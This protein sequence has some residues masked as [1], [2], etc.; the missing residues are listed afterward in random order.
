MLVEYSPVLVKS[1]EQHLDANIHMLRNIIHIS[2][3]SRS[4][5]EKDKRRRG[6]SINEEMR[7]WEIKLQDCSNGGAGSILPSFSLFSPS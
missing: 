7:I 1:K 3:H 4:G 2:N 5:K 6:H